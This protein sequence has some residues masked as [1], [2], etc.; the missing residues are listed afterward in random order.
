MRPQQPTIINL[1]EYQ[2]RYLS[3]E[4]FSA[5]AGELL[6]RNYKNQV[7]VDFPTIKTDDH[8]RLTAQ[9]WVGRIPLT[10]DIHIVLQPKAPL[11]NLFRMLEVAYS[12]N[13]FRFLDGLVQYQSLD[14][15]YTY[16]ARTLSR[17]VLERG[18]KGFQRAYVSQTDTLPYLRGRMD[19]GQIARRPVQAQLQCH[20]Q[21]HTTDIED[22]QLLAWTLF[23]IARSGACAEWA[24]PAVRQAYRVLQGAVTLQPFDSQACLERVYTRLNDDYRPLHALCRFFLEQRGPTHR[25]GDRA[26]MPFLVDMARLYELF[27]AE[28]LQKHA[29]EHLIVKIQEPVDNREVSAIIDV[30][31]VDANTGTTRAVLDTKYKVTGRPDTADIFQV[32]AYAKDKQCRQAILL[33]PAPTAQPLDTMWDDIHV[34]SLTFALDGDLEMAGQQFLQQ[35]LA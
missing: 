11:G 1:T 29:P 35:L 7:E 22:N 27:A 24:L 16:L 15:F 6:H 14:E 5:E 8:W 20:Y 19:T 10:P 17:R 33:Y 23:K 13:S 34:R 21:Q 28:W 32:V 26:M 2:T 31:L 12:L 25:Q 4:Q 30:V 9:G 18:R 3:R